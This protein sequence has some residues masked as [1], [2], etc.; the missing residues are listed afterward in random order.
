M[1]YVECGIGVV[2]C[3]ADDVVVDS[4]GGPGKRENS[5]GEGAI[6]ERYWS[7]TYAGNI[8]RDREWWSN[9]TRLLYRIAGAVP[10]YSSRKLLQKCPG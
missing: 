3:P 9:K 2:V 4:D 7:R 6:N 10:S 8:N 5:E 1:V